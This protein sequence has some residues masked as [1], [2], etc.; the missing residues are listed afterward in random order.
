MNAPKLWGHVC[1]K[2]AQPDRA[3]RPKDY[4]KWTFDGANAMMQ[5][6]ANCER[7]QDPHIQTNKSSKE[8]WDALRKVHSIPAKGRINLF[9]KQFHTYK[10]RPDET[11]D[12]I[13]LAIEDIRIEIGDIKQDHEP[14]DSLDAIA[15]M[16][17]IED[18]ADD[19]AKFMLEGVGSYTRGC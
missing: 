10:A 7:N 18:P 6:R 17:E 2:F 9:L 5:I 3:S 12:E 11:T 1:G 8:V 19:T 16:S 4:D 14:P 15:L 13:A